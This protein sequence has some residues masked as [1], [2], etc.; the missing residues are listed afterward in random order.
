MLSNMET[1]EPFPNPEDP[2]SA[3]AEAEASRTQ[4]AS[5]LV[6]PSFF[7]CAIGAAVAIQIATT[8]PAAAHAGTS[9]FSWA[10]GWWALGGWAFFAL[11]AA[12][13]F[14]R[15]RH[16]NGVRLGGLADQAVFGGARAAFISYGLALPTSMWAAF[17]R[18]WWLVAFCAIAGG[19]AYALI[20]RRWWR[21]YQGDPASQSRGISGGWRAVQFAAAAAAVVLLEYVLNR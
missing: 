9:A 4:F 13:Q 1:S 10:L 18:T 14:V 3:L 12:I 20:G 16:L 2:T 15:F 5:K 17:Y 8:A 6:L 19:A 7:W 21:R 11:V